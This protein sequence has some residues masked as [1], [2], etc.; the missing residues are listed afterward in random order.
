M[1]T[2]KEEI[3]LAA[4]RRGMVWRNAE[5]MAQDKEFGAT[6]AEKTKSSLI[7]KGKKTQD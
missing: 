5:E 1:K 7:P 2:W 6:F 3:E 4:K